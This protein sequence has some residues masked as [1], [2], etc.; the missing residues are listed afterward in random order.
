MIAA[1]FVVSGATVVSNVWRSGLSLD[2]SL[3]LDPVLRGG[4]AGCGIWARGGG[5]PIPVKP[6][7]CEK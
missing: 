4:G 7:V 6:V 5:F 1:V 3:S 2:G